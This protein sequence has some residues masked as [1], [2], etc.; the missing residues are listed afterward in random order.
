MLAGADIARGVCSMPVRILLS[1]VSDEF[2]DY[3]N[4]LCRDLTRDSPSAGRW[5]GSASRPLHSEV[6][7][8][9]VQTRLI[10][11][12]KLPLPEIAD[13]SLVA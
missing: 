6:A 4:Q 12:M 13:V 9:S 2:R 11:I 10:G 1:T 3:S 7:K 5:V 8:K